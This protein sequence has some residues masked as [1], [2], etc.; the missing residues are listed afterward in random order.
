MRLEK[1]NRPLQILDLDRKT[2]EACGAIVSAVTFH[3]LA[4]FFYQLQDLGPQ[5]E[6]RLARR[7]ARSRF[8]PDP[9]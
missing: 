9:S 3:H 6:E 7:A 1:S 2:P 5:P 4:R 8:F